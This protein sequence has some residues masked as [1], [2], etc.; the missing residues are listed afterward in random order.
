MSIVINTKG[1]SFWVKETFY[2][3]TEFRTISKVLFAILPFLLAAVLY[4]L[5]MVIEGMEKGPEFIV[6]LAYG[7]GVLMAMLI[8]LV[9]IISLIEYLRT[10]E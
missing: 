2:G 6:V 8:L 3:E 1:K 5:L 4:T 10:F 7:I 9:I